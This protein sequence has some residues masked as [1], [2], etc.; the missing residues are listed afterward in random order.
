[1]AD[2]E[3]MIQTPQAGSEEAITT[4]NF[5]TSSTETTTK[6]EARPFFLKRDF[7]IASLISLAVTVVIGFFFFKP[8][9]LLLYSDLEQSDAAAIGS[10]LE[11]SKV[12]FKISPEGDKIFV[13]GSS[14][15]KLRLDLANK[16]LPRGS[17]VGFEIFDKTNL[18]VTDFSQKLNYKRA[19]EGELSRSISSLDSIK[20]A[21]VHLALAEKSLFKNTQG[22][23]SASVIVTTELGRELT[24]GQIKGIQHLVASAIQDLKPENVQITDASGKALVRFNDEFSI[25]QEQAEANEKKQ[26]NFESKL[27]QD[28]LALLSPILG[29]GNVMVN[30][31]SEMTFD[32][33]EMNIE[34]FSPLDTQGNPHNPVV[35]SEKTVQEKYT[36]GG[37]QGTNVTGAQDNLPS[38]SG[39]NGSKKADKGYEKQDLTRNYEVSRSVEKIRKATG[40]VKKISVAVVVNKDLNPSERAT[41]RQTVAVAAGLDLERGDQVIVTGI[42]F[43]S[44]PYMNLGDEQERKEQNKQEK[45]AVLKKYITFSVA[46][47]VGLGMV[48]L[49]LLSLQ[50]PLDRKK[51]EALEDMLSEEHLPLLNSIDE[52]IQEA[53]EAFQRKLSLEGKPTVVQMKNE[54]S[55]MATEDPKAIAKS[56][57]AFIDEG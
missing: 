17:G 3:M 57:K 21:R 29:E 32:E 55:K 25:G 14:I 9:Y 10:Y 38:F 33:S 48:L 31:S 52:K 34:L 11:K 27:E 22:K 12:R 1:M 28:L 16:G 23:S 5:R 30:V 40:L 13:A 51:T 46:A 45:M 36:G 24:E 44:T 43:S 53:E 35:R 6:K 4:G 42:R 8:K 56:L 37:P 50:A 15:P 54:L 26:R 7:L 2:Q 47:A 41:L 20:S 39:S 19:L 18:T 49:L